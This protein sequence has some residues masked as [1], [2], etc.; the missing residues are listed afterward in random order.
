M[1]RS[2]IK[3]LLV[4]AFLVASFAAHAAQPFTAKSF[5]DAQAAGKSIVID[6]TASW[7]PVCKVQR[8]IIEGLEKSNPQLAV[9]E[10]DFDK[11]KDVLKQFGVQRQ[12]TLIVFK[13]T[14]EVGRSTGDTDPA[15]ITSLV[16]KGL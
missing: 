3:P 1:F 10:V 13:G 11:S 6:V 14:K 9:F 7:C 2:P 8:P 12:S 5:Q 16:K 4:A 15:S